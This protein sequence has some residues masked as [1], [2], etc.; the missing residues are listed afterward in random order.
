MGV[1]MY[2]L[3]SHLT[4]TE[5]LSTQALIWWLLEEKQTVIKR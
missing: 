4:A 1:D 2:A 5:R 3:F